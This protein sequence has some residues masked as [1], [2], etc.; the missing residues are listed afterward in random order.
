ML[1]LRCTCHRLDGRATWR[2]Q[3]CDDVG[4]FALTACSRLRHGLWLL[5]S[6][7][8]C[9]GLARRCPPDAVTGFDLVV[10]CAR[11]VA[12]RRCFVVIGISFGCAATIA[13]TTEAPPRRTSRRGRIPKRSQAPE[14]DTVPLCVREKASPFWIILLLVWRDPAH[15]RI[16][17][18][19]P[20][21]PNKALTNVRFRG[22]ADMIVCGNPLSRSLLGAKRT[23]PFALHMSAND[24]KR[25]CLT[26]AIT[27]VTVPL[28]S[29]FSRSRRPSSSSFRSRPSSSASWPCRRAPRIASAVRP[30]AP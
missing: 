24:P 25:T 20:R 26:R 19:A 14:L 13:A 11:C 30:S 5:M 4:L 2:S 9:Y 8:L 3:H 10:V 27:M 22:K 23:C 12:P 16:K 28:W 7:Q 1:P 29:S 6:R 18:S 17:L 15:P 21:L